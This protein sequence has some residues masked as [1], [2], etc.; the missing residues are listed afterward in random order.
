MLVLGLQGSPRRRGNSHWLLSRFMEEAQKQGARTETVEICRRH[1]EPCKELI[2]CEKKGYC[3]I[4]DDMKHDVFGLL[5]AADVIVV[6]TPIFFY[7]GTAQLKALIDRC[8]TFWARKYRFRLR[9]P[10][11]AKRRGF[12][13]AVAATAGEALFDGLHLTTKYFFDAV[14]A[15][16]AGSLTYRG[17]EHPGDIANHPTVLQEVAAAVHG[18][19]EPFRH[20]RRVLFVDAADGTLSAM[21]AGICRHTNGDRLDALAAAATPATVLAP[22]AVRAMAQTGLDLEYMRVMDLETAMERHRP[23]VVVTVGE[24]MPVSRLAPTARHLHLPS[25]PADGDDDL[26]GISRALSEGVESV[27]VGIAESPAEASEGSAT[28]G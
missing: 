19:L 25:P 10:G 24:A 9:D 4:D 28:N 6:A 7:N 21:A 1:I 14:S 18:L 23:D 27:T 22:K 8:Q 11:A 5:R 20:R 15:E 13:L 3:P 16:V 17:I 2:V 12:L 26:S